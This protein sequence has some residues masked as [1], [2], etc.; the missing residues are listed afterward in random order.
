MLRNQKDLFYL[1]NDVHYLNNAYMSPNLKSVEIAG[2][3]A[4]R[5][6]NHPY[7]VQIDDFF[8]PLEHLKKTFAK[9][10]NCENYERIAITP[11]ASYGLANAAK[12]IN[13]GNKSKIIIPEGQFPSN[14]YVWE[15]LA[16]EKGLTIEIIEAPK[17]AENRGKI[18]NERIINAIDRNTAIVACAHVHWADGTK[19]NLKEFRTAC[20]RYETYLI[21][22]GTQSI[23]ALSFDIQEIKPDVLV[24]SGYKWLF[25]PYGIGFAYY[26]ERF[27]DGQPIEENWINRKNSEDFKSLVNYQKEYKPFAQK[28]CVGECSKFVDIPMMQTALDQI[29]AW[30]V[31]N[32]QGYSEELISPYLTAFTDLGCK[33]E[34]EDFRA[35]HLIGVKL[36]SHMNIDEL[37]NMM[38]KRNI[39]ISARGNSLRLSTSVYNSKRDLDQ[40]Y[41]VLLENAG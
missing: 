36:A 10:V 1:G 35:N 7:M 8:K 13:C 38:K 34:N 22:D 5:K 29:Y 30:G 9:I 14:Y 27:D 21:I 6:K 39:H 11:S 26:N 37:A 25:G 15:K 24:S 2:I 33:I 3:I 12:N 28:Y 4:V 23:G 32:I 19:F 18:W 41:S 20:D 31:D 17:N 16:E 40:F